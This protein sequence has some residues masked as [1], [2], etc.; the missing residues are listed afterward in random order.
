MIEAK[1]LLNIYYGQNTVRA[2]RLYLRAL[3]YNEIFTLNMFNI[4]LER[5]LYITA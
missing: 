3:R 5:Q 2:L 1:N 4:L